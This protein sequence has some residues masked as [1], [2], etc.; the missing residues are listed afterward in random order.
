MICK[1]LKILKN[2]QNTETKERKKL[3]RERQTKKF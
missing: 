1:K 2:K 3:V